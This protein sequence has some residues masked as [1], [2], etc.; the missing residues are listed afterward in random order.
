MT[1]GGSSV[2][3]SASD[4]EDLVGDWGS[5]KQQLQSEVRFI[6]K[7]CLTYANG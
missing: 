7:A 5:V 2:T 1:K 4:N 3:K 6:S